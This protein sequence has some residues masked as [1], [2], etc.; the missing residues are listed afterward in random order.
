MTIAAIAAAN[1]CI[2]VTDNERGF[3]GIEIVNPIR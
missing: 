2:V 1:N 3:A